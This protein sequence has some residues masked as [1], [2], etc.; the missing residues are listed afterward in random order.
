[1]EDRSNQHSIIRTPDALQ[2]NQQTRIRDTVGLT[3]RFPVISASLE[4]SQL[5]PSIIFKHVQV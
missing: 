1:M 5:L 3:G 2:V 4:A